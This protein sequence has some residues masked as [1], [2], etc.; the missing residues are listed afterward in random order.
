MVCEN[1]L[2]G[3]DVSSIGFSDTSALMK[4]HAFGY[5]LPMSNGAL[6]LAYWYFV[7]RC[8]FRNIERR[9]VVKWVMPHQWV[10]L[11][12]IIEISLT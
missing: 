10:L 9:L 7:W 3:N 4:A 6:H 2:Y 12:L 11:A 1:R 8:H 5:K